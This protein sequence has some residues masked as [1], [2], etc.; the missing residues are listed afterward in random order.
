M[1]ETTPRVSMGAH[2]RIARPALDTRI[3]SALEA[4]GV[5]LIA[6]AGYGKTSLLDDALIRLGD[7]AVWIACSEA[8]AD[9]GRLLVHLIEAMRRALPGL[10]DVLGDRLTGAVDPVDVGEA[11]RDLVRELE[12]LLV[13]PMIVVFDDAEHLAAS[14]E[15]VALIG[16]MIGASSRSL[17]V[18]VASR[19]PLPLRL[20]KL[21]AAGRLLE[22]GPADLAF[23]ASE[24]AELL[25][26]R[27]GSE[28]TAH[29]VEALMEATEGWPLGVALASLAGAGGQL[30]P[31]SRE[32][33]FAFLDEEVLEPMDS[34]FRN[35]LITSSLP[36]ELSGELV[37]A[38]G[39]EPTFLPE[40]QRRGLFLRPVRGDDEPTFTYHPLFREFLLGQ[41]HD[42][43]SPDYVRAV[44]ARIAPLLS[45]SGRHEEAIEHWLDAEH[46]DD[47]IAA[48]A[49]EG[50]WLV[51][52]SPS[53]VEKWIERLPPAPREHPAV[54]LL[55]AQIAWGRGNHRQAA[56]IA[57]D[58]I[59]GFRAREDV[60]GEWRARH[61]MVDA[62]RS[63]GEFEQAIA[64]ADGFD[65]GEAKHAVAAPGVAIIAANCHANLGRFDQAEELLERALRHPA[66]GVWRPVADTVRATQLD[67]PAGRYDE[68]LERIRG[69]VAQ[70]E[71]LDPFN[72]LFLA[73]V[74][75]A[76]IVGDS[77]DSEEA[78]R[79]AGELSR[80]AEAAGIGGYVRPIVHM[81]L[82]GMR[83]REGRLV[84]AEI[85]LKRAGEVSG[86]GWHVYDLDVTSA[87][88]AAARGDRAEAAAAVDRALEAAASAPLN[89]RLR[90]AAELAPVLTEIGD[91]ARARE[92]IDTAI[93]AAGEGFSTARLLALKAWICHGQGEEQAC[94]EYLS[95][96]WDE[97]GDQAQHLVRR[98]WPHLG[99]LLWSALEREV[100]WPG[101]VMP[102]VEAAWPGGGELLPYLDHPDPAVQRVVIPLAAA[103]GHPDAAARIGELAEKEADEGG[104]AASAGTALERLRWSPPPHFYRLLGGFEVQRGTWKIEDS[105][106]E[107]PIAARI[108]RYLLV[109]RGGATPEDALFEAFWPGKTA[110]SARRSLQ[111]QISRIR[112]VLDLPWEDQSAIEVSERSYRLR[113]RDYDLVDVDEFEETAD[114]ALAEEGAA[115]RRLL[116]QAEKLWTGDPLPEDR[117]ADWATAWRERLIDRRLRM[118]AELLDA[119]TREGNAAAAIETGRKLVDL[120]P[121]NEGA[122][123]ELMAAYARAGRT[124]HAL[125]QYLEC[126]RTLV[127]ELGVEPARATSELQA[128]I[129][130]GRAA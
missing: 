18:A 85:E 25:R 105:A 24:A 44:H 118:L 103:S 129:L 96:A 37:A 77:G 49:A 51:R 40:L 73:R 128:R 43:H 19:R 109:N 114:A 3:T 63:I 56:E 15:A 11:E 89:H 110:D 39:L 21:R 9:R 33:V 84:D 61:A 112:A 2:G 107:R 121:L 82:A 93:D 30:T 26:A 86:G 14:A 17:R 23:T 79:V 83:A 127:D 71:R 97:A 122:H 54:E 52:T 29:E 100:L 35:A 13:D 108:F 126:R 62:L 55:D 94:W 90:A 113:L 88:L 119:Y 1:Q 38:L 59:A 45:K 47:A 53:S 78:F 32:E 36:P 57:G 123:R 48:I 92:V 28:P 95:R 16:S 115:R 10:A 111:V 76:L 31:G 124:G 116:E 98:E 58:A 6:E 87:T 130:A 68:A 22:L 104:V 69:A 125:R 81:Y 60:E 46:W 70:L 64:L 102:A 74:G 106:W 72:R 12:R 117:Y 65:A 80:T 99:L 50:A 120:D 8:D 67:L 4:G 20:A 75:E 5:M 66:G 7:D 34:D 42:Q 27:R 91:L 101:A 41:L